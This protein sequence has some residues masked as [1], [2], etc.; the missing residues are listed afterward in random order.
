MRQEDLLLKIGIHTGPCL[1]VMLNDRLDYFGQ[2]VNIAARIQGLAVSDAIFASKPSSTIRGRRRCCKMPASPFARLNWKRT[3][4]RRRRPIGMRPLKRLAQ[5]L[6]D[7][8][9]GAGSSTTE[10]NCRGSRRLG[11]PFGR[12]LILRQFGPS[13]RS[14]SSVA[15]VYSYFVARPASR[16]VRVLFVAWEPDGKLARFRV[17][18]WHDKSAPLRGRHPEGRPQSMFAHGGIR[19]QFGG[20]VKQ[21][22]RLLVIGGCSAYKL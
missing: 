10:A 20:L 15:R 16:A 12:K 6:C 14:D 4:W 1:A 9:R 22:Y 5:S 3:C 21:R 18:R 17:R 19:L 13:D 2:T 7:Y 11:A 8:A